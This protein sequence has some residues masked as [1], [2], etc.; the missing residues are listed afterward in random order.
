MFAESLSGAGKI[1]A[2]SLFHYQPL[3]EERKLNFKPYR[4]AKLL[5][6]DVDKT[7]KPIVQSEYCLSS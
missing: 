1:E 7:I 2:T 6:N 5:Y 3:L 4:E